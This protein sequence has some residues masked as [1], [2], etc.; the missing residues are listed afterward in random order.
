MSV[1]NAH[2]YNLNETRSYPLSE[3]GS[4]LSDQ[5]VRLPSDIFTDM[6]IRYPQQ[7]GRYPFLG[8]VSVTENLVSFTIQGADALT[9]S[10]GL[11]PI[12]V[13]TRPKS[14]IVEGRQ[15]PVRGQVPGV[16]G[17]VVF[18]SG[19]Q[20]AYT[21]R[22]S[23]GP[24]QSLIL[25]NACRWYR[26]LPVD[27]LSGMFNEDKLTGVIQLRGVDPVFVVKEEREIDGVLR[28]VIVVRLVQPENQGQAIPPNVFE[29]FAGRCGKRPESGN[30]GNP[31]PIEFIN[32]VAPNCNGE[33]FIEFR[34]CAEIAKILGDCGVAVDCQLGLI[35]ACLPDHLPVDGELPNE[36]EDQCAPSES[37]SED[38][39]S[40][41]EEPSESIDPPPESE[42]VV[43]ELPYL[44]CFD[45]QTAENWLVE[46][47]SWSFID[48]DSPDE[49]CVDVPEGYSY[50][51]SGA[52]AQAVRNLAVWSG[53][54]DQASQRRVT[55]SLKLSPGSSGARHNG[56]VVFNYRDHLLIDGRKVYF[57][58]EIDFE[59][60]VFRIRRFNGTA[61]VPIVSTT[62]PG[63]ALN[64]WY[65]I[66]VT[67]EDF[68]AD[69]VTITAQLEGI[70][71]PSIDVQLGPFVSSTYLP[72]TGL[73]GLH[74]NRANTRFSYFQLEA[75]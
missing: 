56:G 53:F 22:F 72:D 55:T 18:G 33:V 62:V 58:A 44:E 35:D 50:Y 40:V 66:T 60:Q 4:L 51:T 75:I 3:T 16:G 71:N 21:G 11:T 26:P 74:A 29:Q 42:S 59:D 48:D 27:S 61:F 57:L 1:R 9:G 17:W 39:D 67:V 34:G 28:D 8:S 46:N 38:S 70:T 12:A 20:E 6:H 64:Q 23:S 73:M 49:P 68:D 7:L 52:E 65:R 15:Y 47:G 10:P 63:I 5:G 45:S 36:Y 41:P 30:C 43:G 13:F 32:T 24:S 54:D 2:F 19:I 69:D 14:Q 25:P 31:E 37:V